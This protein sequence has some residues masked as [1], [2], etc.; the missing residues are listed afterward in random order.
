MGNKWNDIKDAYNLTD[1][2][3][4]EMFNESA[5]DDAVTK[6]KTIRFSQNPTIQEYEGSAL[7]NEWGY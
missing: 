7:A 1:K 3:M 2:D 5:I 6:G 4:F